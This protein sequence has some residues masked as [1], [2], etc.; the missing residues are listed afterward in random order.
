[1]AEIAVGI[2]LGTSNTCVAL[3]RG[4]EV[5]VLDNAFVERTTASVVHF[6]EDRSVDVANSA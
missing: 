4:G 2:D 3:M 6:R 5:R 1:M